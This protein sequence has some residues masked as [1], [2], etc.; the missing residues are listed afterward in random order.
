[1][2][3]V[4]VTDKGDA[5][6]LMCAANESLSLGSTHWTDELMQNT[7]GETKEED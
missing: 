7:E 1:M 6:L 5:A 2:D 4:S 3:L